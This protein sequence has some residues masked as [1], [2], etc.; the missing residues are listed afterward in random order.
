MQILN[1]T[2]LRKWAR[3][4]GFDDSWWFSIG[5]VTCGKP[6]K[7]SEVPR[8]SQ[9]LLLNA[10][11]QNTDKE[12]WL[13]FRYPG[14]KNPD[15]TTGKDKSENPPTIKQTL[16]LEFFGETRT[17]TRKQA[18]ELLDEYFSL[19]TNY[20]RYQDFLWDHYERIYSG[21]ELYEKT[22]ERL[23]TQM[24]F[25]KENAAKQKIESLVDEAVKSS[26][27]YKSFIEL[28]KS[29]HPEIL[30]ADATQK[31]KRSEYEAGN[32]R[33]QEWKAEQNRDKKSG[34][35]GL[36]VLLLIPTIVCWLV[37]NL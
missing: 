1:I 4:N 17:V 33:S 3:E 31:R 28:V 23:Q 5:G 24:F 29:R 26:I 12:E 32:L 21:R 14:Y 27:H 35:L 7:L 6:V 30:L 18:S 11:S 15:A 16:A 34:C 10:G 20:G 2:E 25:I 22:V 19:P 37:V 8:E 36:M 13:V 9:V